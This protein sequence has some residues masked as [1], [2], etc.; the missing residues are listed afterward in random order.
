MHGVRLYTRAQLDANIYVLL[1]DYFDDAGGEVVES[2]NEIAF[3]VE[4]V[5][6]FGRVPS[7]A[8]RE[9]IADDS[10]LPSDGYCHH[11][12]TFVIENLLEKWALVTPNRA[13]QRRKR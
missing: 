2:V 11:A 13:P 9:R 7:T 5:I 6:E 12:I 10:A 8:H 1:L 4:Y 3:P